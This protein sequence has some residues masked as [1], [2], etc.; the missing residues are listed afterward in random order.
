MRK[1]YLIIIIIC[2]ICMGCH[3]LLIAIAPPYFLVDE[4]KVV[5]NAETETP[6][7][8]WL[9]RSHGKRVTF[10]SLRSRN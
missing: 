1:L 4:A 10:I 6:V 7:P 5:M 2:S 3:G 9:L 8:A